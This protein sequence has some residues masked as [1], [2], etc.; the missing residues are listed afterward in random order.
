[1]SIGFE[2][3]R[4]GENKERKKERKKQT[5]TQTKKYEHKHAKHDT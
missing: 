2:I 5:N 1:M 3:S 4:A